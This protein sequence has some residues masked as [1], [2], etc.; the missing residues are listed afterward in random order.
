MW[1]C[2]SCGAKNGSEKRRCSGM[3]PR[4]FCDKPLGGEDCW[5]WV[6]GRFPG[7]AERSQMGDG[8]ENWV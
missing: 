1:E 3:T 8:W 2:F 7:E 5:V 6:V 4:G